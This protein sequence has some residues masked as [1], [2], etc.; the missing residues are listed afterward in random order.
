[1]IVNQNHGP[2]TRLLTV[3]HELAHLYLGHLGEDF[4]LGIQNRRGLTHEQAEIEAESVAFL[5]CERNGVTAKSQ[6]YLSAFV[7]GDLSVDGIGLYQIMRVAG[8]IETLLGLDAQR[9]H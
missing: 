5:V 9:K 3:A 4:K 1:L 6:T 2:P 8:R 7:T